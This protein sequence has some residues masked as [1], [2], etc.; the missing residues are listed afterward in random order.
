MTLD[1]LWTSSPTSRLC[2]RRSLE[3]MLADYQWFIASGG[4]IKNAKYYN[5]CIN[6]PFFK[7]TLSQVPCMDKTNFKCILIS[8]LLAGLCSLHITQGIFLKLFS[9]FEEACHRIDLKL[10]LYCPTAPLSRSQFDEYSKA[11]K[12]LS[13]IIS[14]LE[15][16]HLEEE[17]FQ[18]LATYCSIS[19]GNFT[20]FI[21]SLL[22][23]S[24]NWHERRNVL[25]S[26][27]F[28]ADHK[29]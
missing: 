11:L 26:Y 21:G 14:E 28:P 2:A 22:E 16:V 15:T 19:A 12:D 6:E 23:L 4:D 25:V 5:N 7:K 9:M 20:P 3:T 27:F 8:D 24:S 29:L 18:Q 1:Q 17:T 13:E 10:A